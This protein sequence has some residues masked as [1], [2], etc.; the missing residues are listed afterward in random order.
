MFT[1]AIL[2]QRDRLLAATLGRNHI[3]AVFTAC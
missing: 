3:N 1:G 2:F